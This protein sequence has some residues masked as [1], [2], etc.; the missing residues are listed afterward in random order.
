[1]LELRRHNGIKVTG[2]VSDIF[3]VY[4]SHLHLWRVAGAR[5]KMPQPGMTRAMTVQLKLYNHETE[6]NFCE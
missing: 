5:I 2:S 1:M 4:V 3:S 6:A